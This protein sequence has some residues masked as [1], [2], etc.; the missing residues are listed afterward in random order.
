MG[1][2]RLNPFSMPEA[3]TE[4]LE[5]LLIEYGGPGLALFELAHAVETYVLAS[6]LVSTAVPPAT[7]SGLAIHLALCIAVV[8]VFTLVE[9]IV[10]RLRLDQALKFY[11][12]YSTLLGLAGLILAAL[13]GGIA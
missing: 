12:V 4:I 1:K 3:E 5:R 7:P 11:A 2:L 8:A 13:W 10:A 9:C 6:V